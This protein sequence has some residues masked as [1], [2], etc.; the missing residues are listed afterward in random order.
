M[1]SPSVVTLLRQPEVSARVNRAAVADHLRHRWPRP[2]ETYFDG[3][4]RVL[5]GHW[6]RVHERRTTTERYWDPLFPGQHPAWID[7]EDL[8]HFDQ[9]LDDSVTRLMA[10]GRSGIYLSGGLDSVSVAGLAADHARRRSEQPPCALSLAFP[11]PFSEADVQRSVA[12]QL[13]MPHVLASLED[14]LAGDGIVRAAVRRGSIGAP[15]QNP[16]LPAYRWLAAQAADG[17]CATVLTG[18][19]G[20]EWLTV[21]PMYAADLLRSG[22][23]LGL[24]ALGRTQA[25]SFN[26]APSVLARNLVWRF[27]LRPLWVHRRAAVMQRWAPDRYV[28]RRLQR[29][30]HGLSHRAWLAPDPDLRRELYARDEEY[31]RVPSDEDLLP[32]SGPREYFREC[33]QALT[34]PLVSMEAE[35]VFE[36][37]RGVGVQVVHPYWDTRLVEFLHATPPELLIRGGRSKALI[38]SMLGR[39]FP[40]LGFER[41]RKAITASYFGDSVLRQAPGVWN[42][43]GGARGLE[44]AGIVDSKIA[45]GLYEPRPVNH[46]NGTHAVTDPM[47]EILTVEGWL[48]HHV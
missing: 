41:Q 42:E 15:I 2:D 13:G 27:G 34:H 4:H 35:E 36:Y 47:W 6:L 44:E 7:P 30:Q 11:D 24:A 14:A 12:S 8:G 31:A 25:R 46:V 18:S 1:V 3:V 39:R 22:R 48:R 5:P 28:E 40:E 9:L 29:L 16:W 37:S 17:G 38:R 19:G 33:R 20:D 26:V 32:L 45:A 23:L 43:M 10:G 21:S